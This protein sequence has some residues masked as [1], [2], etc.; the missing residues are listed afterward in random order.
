MLNLTSKKEQKQKK[1]EAEKKNGDKDEKAQCELMSNAF[2]CKTM[3][4][5]RKGID[6]KV[7]DNEK[8]CL[9]WTSNQAI[10]HEKYLT[11]I[12]FRYVKVKLH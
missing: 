2:Y 5:L 7:L 12:Q 1:I 3:E 6:V 8:G 11:I 10:C 9:K 4:N